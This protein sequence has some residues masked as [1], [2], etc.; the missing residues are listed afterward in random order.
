MTRAEH[1]SIVTSV[2]RVVYLPKIPTNLYPRIVQPRHIANRLM[3]SVSR[4]KGVVATTM[5]KKRMATLMADVMKR[6]VLDKCFLMHRSTKGMG[7]ILTR[8]V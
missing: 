4:Y 5:D 2:Y 3:L 7:P 1:N 8:R 6:W